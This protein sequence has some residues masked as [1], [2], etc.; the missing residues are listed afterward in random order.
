[1]FLDFF[2]QGRKTIPSFLSVP[3]IGLGFSLDTGHQV[4]FGQPGGFTFSVELWCG[5]APDFSSS[6]H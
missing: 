6:V 3:K 1:M 5:L 2:I 4:G